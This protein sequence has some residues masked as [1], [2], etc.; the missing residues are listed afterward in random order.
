MVNDSVHLDA[1]HSTFVLPSPDPQQVNPLA[2][3]GAFKITAEFTNEG[4]TD[5]CDVAFDVVTLD[6]ASGATP[7]ALDRQG[8]LI[9]GEGIRFPATLAGGR[10][11]LKAN[12]HDRY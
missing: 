6:G 5:I 11:D 8:Q 7:V 3:S 4:A 9:G 10:E 2:R 12:E 1:L